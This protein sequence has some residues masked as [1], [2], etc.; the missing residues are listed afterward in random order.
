MSFQ[1]DGLQMNPV[2]SPLA[3]FIALSEIEPILVDR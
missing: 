2:G 3:G 1:L